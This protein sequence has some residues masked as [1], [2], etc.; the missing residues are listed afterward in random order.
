MAGEEKSNAD[1]VLIWGASYWSVSHGAGYHQW[2]E[3]G[4][5][6]RVSRR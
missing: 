4:Q 6:L 1:F 5:G 2:N 3:N